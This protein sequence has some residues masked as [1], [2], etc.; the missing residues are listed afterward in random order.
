[1]P[2]ADAAIAAVLIGTGLTPDEAL[3]LLL[4][5]V[6]GQDAMERKGQRYGLTYWQHTGVHAVELD[7]ARR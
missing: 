2:Q 1:V 4:H 5:S 3:S 6:R 7:S